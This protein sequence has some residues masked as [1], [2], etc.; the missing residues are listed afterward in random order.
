M[1]EVG[2]DM[3]VFIS[4]PH[5]RPSGGTKYLNLFVNL[6]NDKGITSYMVLPQEPIQ[7]DFLNQPAPV[8]DACKMLEM[9]SSDDVTLS[10]ACLSEPL[11]GQ[12]LYASSCHF[13]GP[14]D[15][16]GGPAAQSP[17]TAMRRRS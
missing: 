5:N 16:I 9:C 8:I 3:R 4:A 11:F 1:E 2:L 17:M 7:S 14:K 13:R 10:V 12:N 15:P 6:F